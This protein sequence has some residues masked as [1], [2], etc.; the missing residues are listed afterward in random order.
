MPSESLDGELLKA[1]LDESSLPRAVRGVANN[2]V[3]Q[4]LQTLSS[5]CL[6]FLIFFPHL[7]APILSPNKW[8]SSLFVF[9]F[10]WARKGDPMP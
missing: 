1:L 8:S 3:E 9:Y 7:L 4:L 2:L 10:F 5:E 6:R